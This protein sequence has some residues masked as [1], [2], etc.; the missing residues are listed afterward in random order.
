MKQT[1]KIISLLLLLCG[2]YSS[3][4]AQPYC[5]NEVT[6]VF[7]DLTAFLNSEYTLQSRLELGL[8]NVSESEITVMNDDHHSSECESLKELQPFDQTR[9]TNV[10]PGPDKITY[11]KIRNV[12]VVVVNNFRLHEV[13]E[14]E[15][16]IDSVPSNIF[17]F[18]SDFEVLKSLWLW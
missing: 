11:F 2:L 13:D 3:S 7:K 16:W 14:D 8:A 12:Y 15:I 18:N 6:E 17:V 1:M 5:P 10:Y 9:S 4:F